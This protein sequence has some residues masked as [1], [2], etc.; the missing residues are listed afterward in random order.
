MSM[1]VEQL[2]SQLRYKRGN[3]SL[4]TIS[5]R[6][7]ISAATLSRIERGAAPSVDTYMRICDWLGISADTFMGD[8]PEILSH[9]DAVLFHL[10]ADKTLS[11]ETS[12]ALQTIVKMAYNSP[13]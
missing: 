4:R 13:L 1:D 8:A 9:K 11:K 12:T 5:A 6:T 7:G 10:R 3:N 2:S